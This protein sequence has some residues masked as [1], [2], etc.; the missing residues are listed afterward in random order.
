EKGWNR[1][2]EW[3]AGERKGLLVRV[4]WGVDGNPGLF[5]MVRFPRTP[6]LASLRQALIDDPTLEILPGKGGA[7]RKMAIE[8][9]PKKMV[10]WS[11]IPEFTLTESSLVW[12]ILNRFSMPKPAHLQSWVDAL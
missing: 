10:R 12:R 11:G 3:I 2:T 9:G 8:T 4:S 6:D 1:R 5:V 7:R